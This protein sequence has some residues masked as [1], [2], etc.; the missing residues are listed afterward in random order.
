MQHF[1]FSFSSFR[2]LDFI[3]HHL[4]F[5]LTATSTQTNQI[6]KVPPSHTDTI[7][8]CT[9]IELDQIEVGQIMSAFL[10]FCDVQID[11]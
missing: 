10:S 9:D 3:S 4:S 7:I 1:T 5:I 11:L 2:Y 8:D 6:S